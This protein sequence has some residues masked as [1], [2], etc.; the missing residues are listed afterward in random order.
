MDRDLTLR[1]FS[2]LPLTARDRLLV[3]NEARR[4]P[5]LLR[6]SR[7]RSSLNHVLALSQY[8]F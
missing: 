6:S 3:V 2:F 4:Q 5:C 8:L 7:R 1:I